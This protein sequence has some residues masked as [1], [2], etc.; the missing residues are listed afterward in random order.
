MRIRTIVKGITTVPLSAYVNCG[1]ALK[2][3]FAL[4]V[5]ILAYFIPITLLIITRVD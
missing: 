5:V 4:K 1:F 3:S 2:P